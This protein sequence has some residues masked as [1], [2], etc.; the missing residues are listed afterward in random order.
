MSGECPGIRLRNVYCEQIVSGGIAT[1]VDESLC[2]AGQKPQAQKLC[3]D[4]EASTDEDSGPQV[5]YNF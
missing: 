5:R 1:V 4:D 2:E 3:T